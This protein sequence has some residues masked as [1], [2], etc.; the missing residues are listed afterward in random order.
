[1]VSRAPRGRSSN[2][3]RRDILS[4]RA[5]VFLGQSSDPARLRDVTA[6]NANVIPSQRARVTPWASRSSLVFIRLSLLPY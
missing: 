1:M 4:D 3:Q 2:N 5:H 6:F